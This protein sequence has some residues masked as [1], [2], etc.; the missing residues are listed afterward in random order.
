MNL[1]YLIKF[2]KKYRLFMKFSLYHFMIL[3]KLFETSVFNLKGKYIF[4][5]LLFILLSPY[6]E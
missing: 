1:I 6:I 3:E 2:L 5:S 4:F